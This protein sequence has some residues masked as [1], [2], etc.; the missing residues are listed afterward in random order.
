[1]DLCN[2]VVDQKGMSSVERRFF[3]VLGLFELHIVVVAARP[4]ICQCPAVI[5]QSLIATYIVYYYYLS[6]LQQ[7]AG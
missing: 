7:V 6:Q 5:T 3:S 4:H 2:G 1:M